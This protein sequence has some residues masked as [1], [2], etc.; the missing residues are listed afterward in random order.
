MM[1][2]KTL[3]LVFG[4]LIFLHGLAAS[5]TMTPTDQV[6]SAVDAVLNT[7]KLENLDRGAKREK[8]R[9]SLQQIFY[10]RAMSQRTLATNWRKASA[11]EKERFVNLFSRLLEN[12][13]MGKIE[14]YTDERVE[15]TGEKIKGK[16]AI[17][18][19]M[20]VTGSV[21]IPISYKTVLR[22]EKWLIYDVVVEEVSLI[23]NYR[24][25][26][27]QIVKKEGIDGLLSKM[28]Q[29]IKQQESPKDQETKGQ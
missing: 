27:K 20:I 4:S 5:A 23:S 14:A 12:T 1:V 9:S 17:V 18:D 16:K 7:L 10:Y 22:D 2:R 6:R 19:T 11:A 26:Y 3:F 21:N 29:K 8:I 24:S 25:S 13:Y 15:Y 28:E